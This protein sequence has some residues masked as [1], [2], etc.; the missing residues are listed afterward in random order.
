MKVNGCERL[1]KEE[2]KW[3]LPY[4]IRFQPWKTL[5]GSMNFCLDDLVN[6]GNSVDHHD[7]F[8]KI[9]PTLIKSIYIKIICR[10]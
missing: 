2:N 1:M 9:P 3:Y 10:F 4:A 8:D 6:T 7:I 5:A